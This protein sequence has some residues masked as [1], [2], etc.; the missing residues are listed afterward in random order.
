MES[1]KLLIPKQQAYKAYS[2]LQEKKASFKELQSKS[3]DKGDP[4][5]ALEWGMCASVVNE[6]M[7]VIVG[8]FNLKF[9]Q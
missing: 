9:E 5:T 6:C 7:H 1:D 4:E 2:R 3:R 8:E